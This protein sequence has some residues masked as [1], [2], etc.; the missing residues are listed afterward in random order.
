MPSNHISNEP[1]HK[2][3]KEEGARKRKAMAALNSLNKGVDLALSSDKIRLNMNTELL[4]LVLKYH[5]GQM[6]VGNREDGKGDPQIEHLLRVFVRL[7]QPCDHYPKSLKLV[8]Q[9][10]T[11]FMLDVALAHD[12]L[13]DTEVTEEEL[14]EVL[15][16]YA[17]EA[18]K[19]LTRKKDQTYFD[20]IKD[21]V[22][23]N[24]MASLVKLADLE[25]NHENAIPSLQ[26]R[27]EKAKGIIFDHWNNTVFP[28][29]TAEDYPGEEP[30]AEEQEKEEDKTT[31]VLPD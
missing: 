16:E 5:A 15:N 2:W 3:L 25:D 9:N 7:L 17:L 14:A 29:P 21:Q 27:Y 20:Y 4:L 6:R 26:G 28:D 10:A 31:I 12:M 13:E 19:A 11:P 24:P 22:L 30:G 1:Y 8:R 18:V 23:T